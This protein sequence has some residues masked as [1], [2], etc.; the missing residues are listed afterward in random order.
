MVGWV[1]GMH[2]PR[3]PP[4]CTTPDT[5]PPTTATG[6]MTEHV[7]T[8]TKYGHGAHIRRPTH[9]EGTLVAV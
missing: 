9:L 7:R 2:P 1:P 3:H 4:A 5:P 6:V 8:T